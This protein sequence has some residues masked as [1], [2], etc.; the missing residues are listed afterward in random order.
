M[1][2]TYTNLLFHIVFATKGRFPFIVKEHRERL[3][4]YIGGTV[5][6]LGGICIEIGGVADHIHMIVRLKPNQDISDLLQKLKPGVTKWARQKIHPKF[7]WQDGYGAFT[8]GESQLSAVR[9]YIQDQEK[10]HR[11][12]PF[13][14]EFKEMLN[15]AG[16][17]FDEQYLWS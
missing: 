13:D 11:K 16:I 5:R 4:E 17:D 1:P 12:T 9:R 7:E 10:H 15:R 8:I 6:A 2:R 3:Y 14:E